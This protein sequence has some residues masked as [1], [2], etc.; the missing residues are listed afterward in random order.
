MSGH[1]EGKRAEELHSH[2]LVE[3]K[4]ASDTSKVESVFPLPL[5]N[6]FQ[7]K[8]LPKGKHLLRL[9]SG[10][11]LSTHRFESEVIEVDLDKHPQIHIG[12]LKYF[13]EEDY[14]KQVCFTFV[15]MY[16]VFRTFLIGS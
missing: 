2:L 11:P 9:K 6:F 4:S 3:I 5:S 15:V 13:I 14:Q 8:D 16:I 7:V 1:V 12:P 10:L